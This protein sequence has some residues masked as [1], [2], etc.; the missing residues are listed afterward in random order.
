MELKDQLAATGII[1]FV[2][3]FITLM[4]LAGLWTHRTHEPL[5]VRLTGVLAILFGVTA[6]I[7]WLAAVWT[8]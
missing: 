7:F 3:G 6:I 5:H 2:A 4:V 1:L 8:P